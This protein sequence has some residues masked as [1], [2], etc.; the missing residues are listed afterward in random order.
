MGADTVLHAPPPAPQMLLW[1]LQLQR[2]SQKLIQVSLLLSDFHDCKTKLHSDVWCFLRG[3]TVSSA[4]DHATIYI[5]V[6][7]GLGFHFAEH[8]LKL[9]IV[10]I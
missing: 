2:S 3:H 10:F 6:E 7:T 4:N 9:Q 8:F 1:G 5:A